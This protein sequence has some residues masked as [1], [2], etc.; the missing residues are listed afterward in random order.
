MPAPASGP[1]PWG[2]CRNPWEH[3]AWRCPPAGTQLLRCLTWPCKALWAFRVHD[4][5]PLLRCTP[6]SLVRTSSSFPLPACHPGRYLPECHRATLCLPIAGDR[7]WPGKM[8]HH[9]LRARVWDFLWTPLGASCD[10]GGCWEGVEL[11]SSCT[12]CWATW[13][14]WGRGGDGAFRCQCWR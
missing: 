8:S 2:G 5:T 10:P 11:P 3:S 14:M 4:C 1:P 7:E 6:V 9:T 13:R 12:V